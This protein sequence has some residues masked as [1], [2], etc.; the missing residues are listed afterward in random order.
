MPLANVEITPAESNSPDSTS[1][2]TSPAVEAPRSI[3][4]GLIALAGLA[5]YSAP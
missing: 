4:I 1:L 3:D 5:S 2:R